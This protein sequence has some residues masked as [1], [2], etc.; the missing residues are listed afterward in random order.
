[1]RLT[2]VSIAGAVAGALAIG[3]LSAGSGRAKGPANPAPRMH[4]VD[5]RQFAFEP[6]RLEVAAGDTVIWVNA[7]VVP[8]TA[9]AL[10]SAWTSPG[11]SQD[12]QWRQVFTRPGTHEY[13]CAY[14]PGMRG[15]VRVLP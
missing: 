4:R 10:D 2:A 7:D 14:H 12:G 3:A 13:L 9:T 8:H 15:V 1:M 5:I 11:L 6:V